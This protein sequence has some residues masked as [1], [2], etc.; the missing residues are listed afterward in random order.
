MKHNAERQWNIAKSM[1]VLGV[2]AARGGSK[3]VPRKNVHPIKGLPLIAW[4]ILAAK[5]SRYLGRV[6]VSSDDSE[7][8]SVAKQYGGEAPFVRPDE[9]ATDEAG[10]AEVVTHAIQALEDRYDLVVLLQPTSPL[11]TGSDIDAAIDLLVST[12][13]PSVMSVC[14]VDKS[15]YWM[16]TLRPDGSLTALFDTVDR[17]A[18]RQDAPPVYMPN[19]AVYVV[20]CEQFMA[21]RTFVYDSTRALVMP[22][23]RSIDVDTPLDFEM[24]D[25]L[26][27]Q[28]PDLVPSRSE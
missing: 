8:I 5:Q 21:D 12:D 15:P 11:R 4:T 2:I 20:R 24:L 13:A 26:C 7:I 14:R 23:W 27:E 25:C 6:V 22:T 19:G 17:P 10:A 18:R 28:H 9:L 1:R 3:G 16:Y